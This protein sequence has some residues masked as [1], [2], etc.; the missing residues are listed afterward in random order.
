VL[1]Y[2]RPYWRQL[3]VIG[4]LSLFSTALSLAVP[5]L[6]KVLVDRALVGRDVTALY[7]TV[8]L[9][10]G[11]SAAA[12]VISTVTGL[13]YARVSANILFDMRLAVYRHLQ[14][15]SPRFYARTPLGEIVARINNDIGEI[16][17][18]AAES[19]LAWAG[20]VLFLCG[21][22]A[23]MF[24][25]D[26]RLAIFALA[27]VPASAWTLSRIRGTLAVRVRTLREASAAVGTFLIDTLQATRTIVLSNAQEREVT[28]FRERNDRF[29]A[30][31]MSMQLW[32]YLAG[33]LPGLVLS[34]GYAALFIYGG[35]RVIGGTLTLGTFVAFLAYQMRVVQPVQALMG[36][37]ASFATVQVSVARVR[38]LLDAPADVVESGE[39]VWLQQVR[40]S[41]AFEHVSIDL[42]RGNVLCDVSFRVD[43]GE[44]VAIV[45]PS[46]IGKSTIVDL[47]SR[48]LDPDGGRVT[49]DGHDLRVLQLATVRAAV[50]VVEQE[51]ALFRASI[52]DNIRYA[53]PEADDEAIRAAALR[54]GLDDL[55]TRLPDGLQTIVGERG[56]AMSAG[57][58]QRV[59]IAR[60]LLR[61]APVVVLDEPTAALDAA[62]AHAIV[63]TLRTVLHGR[64]IVVVTH[65][66][67]VAS[68][69]DRVL[70]LTVDGILERTAASAI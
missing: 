62:A 32:S 26:A 42:G 23:A 7:W 9:F 41:I 12:F 14:R 17:R 56:Q 22:V 28:R 45:G 55:I 10:T 58:R 53:V 21:S 15:L 18:V 52:A 47:V 67:I 65:S 8:A 50:A 20:N 13:R 39:T 1:R 48:M 70:E 30:A 34:A 66:P 24:W 61:E 6:S 3:G 4:G 57:E 44:L 64:T 60:A 36:L 49:I 69:A 11:T 25:L 38:E 2:V 29:I 63:A 68:A 40:G 43:R 5:Y 27:I 51:P 31:L 16:Q 59:A 35:R 33:S 54:A 46:G 19:V 37:Y